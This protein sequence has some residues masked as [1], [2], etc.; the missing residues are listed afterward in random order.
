[1][2]ALTECKYADS[3]FYCVFGF[4]RHVSQNAERPDEV[5]R[6][7]QNNDGHLGWTNVHDAHPRVYKTR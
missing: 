3:L 4:G 2:S 5:F 1:M 6:E 7:R